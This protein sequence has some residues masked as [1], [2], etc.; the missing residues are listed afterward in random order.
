MKKGLNTFIFL[1]T[2]FVFSIQNCMGTETTL[3][4]QE[5]ID[6]NSQS[7]AMAGASVAGVK[8]SAGVAIN[9][10]AA[11][12]VENM[13]LFVGY[14]TIMDGVWGAPVVFSRN[15]GKYGVFSVLITGLSSG[16]IDVIDE[17]DGEPVY[18]DKIAESQYLTGAVSWGY[19]VMKD[20]SVGATM[21][22]LYNRINDGDQI[23]SAKG[24]ALD[25]GVLYLLPNK[26]FTVGATVKNAGFVLK[27]FDDRNYNLPFLVEAGL[28][29]IQNSTVKLALDINKPL[30]DYI[31]FEPAIDICIKKVLSLRLGYSFSHQD[32]TKFIKKL[33]GKE[34]EN[35]VK[36]NWNT[37]CTGVGINTKVNKTLLNIDLALQFHSSQLTPSTIVS[38]SV[39]F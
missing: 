27:G 17:L 33:S 3:F 21:K 5:N 30:G 1:T 29:Y 36:S 24:L 4:P 7:A 23:Y 12:S 20:L 28:S 8:G 31:N 38:A 14:R 13:Q 37:F 9:P 10:A 34:D 19:R 15:F 39:D 11:V 6:F 25:A 22:G 26:R 35:Y 2:V 18:T 16:E 32:L